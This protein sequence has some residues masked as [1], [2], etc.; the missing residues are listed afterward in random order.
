MT[1]SVCRL[2]VPNTKLYISRVYKWPFLA[3]LL[4]VLIILHVQQKTT[5]TCTFENW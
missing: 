4:A 2:I 5:V 1:L 3:L